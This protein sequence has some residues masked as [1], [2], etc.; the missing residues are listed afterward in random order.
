MFAQPRYAPEALVPLAAGLAWLALAFDAGLLAGLLPAL[1]GLLLLGCGVTALLLRGDPRIPQLGGIGGL[2][3]ALFALPA[4][5]LAG[6]FEGL[7]LLLLSGAAFV[8]AGS[9]SV[10]QESHV[11]GVPLP[12]P[13][14]R[15]AAE[16]AADDAIL[17]FMLFTFP[18]LS[19]TDHARSA[20]E[21]RDA[22]ALFAEK[23][24]LEKPA[25]Y[26]ATPPPPEAPRLARMKV[27]RLEVEHLSFESGYAPHE[28]EPGRDRW[29]GYTANRT[30][31][32]WVLRHEAEAGAERP[33]LVCIHGYQMGTPAI[34][35][36][37][38][39]AERLH[40]RLGLN[41]LFPVLP[42]HG[43]RKRS[44]V[45]GNGFISSDFVDTLHAE[46]QA[47]WDVR[48]LLAWVR[49]QGGA[50]VG[51][52]GL[53]LGGYQTALLAGLEED[54]ACVVAGIPATDFARL[55]WRH[56]PPLERR[57]AEFLGLERQA[58]E[59]VLSVV[60]PLALPAR[61]PK[62]RLAIFAAVSDLLVPADQPRDLWR[63]WGE[64]R[65][66]WYPGSHMTFWLHP[67][68][69]SLMDDSLRGAGLVA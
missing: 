51:V 10:R 45:S 31:H 12:E 28:D 9:L 4:L 19:A 20:G 64:P 36:A 42:L 23:G 57:E 68:V 8:A 15:R 62:E 53:S 22:A 34:D 35:L 54:L 58:V 32:A 33:W 65:I 27:R 44:R 69:R 24:W 66:A 40:R 50:R 18:N 2:V 56:A 37:A 17:G 11:E 48:R 21:V 55:V 26:H 5:F 7:L 6:P 61:V 47:M 63:H 59:R 14:L 41:L 30:A 29:L 52:T 43:P 13:G 60:S 1:P 39:Q 38:F 67:G 16:V 46:A 49:A 25:L 3:G